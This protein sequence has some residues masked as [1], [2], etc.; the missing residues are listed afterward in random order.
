MKVFQKRKQGRQETWIYLDAR[1]G[2]QAVA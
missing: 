1:V 2:D